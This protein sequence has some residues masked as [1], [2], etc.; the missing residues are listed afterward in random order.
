MILL[1]KKAVEFSRDKYSA[2]KIKEPLDDQINTHICFQNFLILFESLL[3][4]GLQ[5]WLDNPD[6]IN[7]ISKLFPMNCHSAI[8]WLISK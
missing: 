6:W 3:S 1:T 2:H 8:G 5:I 7:L 4:K